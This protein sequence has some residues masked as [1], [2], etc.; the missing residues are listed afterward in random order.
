MD[1]Q[2]VG[3]VGID[4]PELDQE[5]EQLGQA[6][7]VPARRRIEPQG[8]EARHLEPAELGLG[9][10]PLR[11]PAHGTGADLGEDRPGSGKRGCRSE[12]RGRH[13]NPHRSGS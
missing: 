13:P 8:G 1:A 11:V 4:H 10:P 12:D 3:H 9:Q 5:S 7:A 6:G 2:R